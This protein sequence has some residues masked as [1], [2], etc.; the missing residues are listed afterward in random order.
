MN[1]L[2]RLMYGKYGSDQLSIA[3]LVVA[4]LISIVSPFLKM[5]W[6]TLISTLLIILC[7]VRMFSKNFGKRREEN[8]RFLRIYQPIKFKVQRLLNRQKDQKV[9]KYFKCPKCSKTIR[10]PR[11]KG[12]IAI[13]CPM[14]REEFVRK[15]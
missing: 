7:Y 5:N 14:C 12:K 6:L 4:V 10:I 11:G 1:W 8:E 3:L 13:T 15:S 2:R 9:Y